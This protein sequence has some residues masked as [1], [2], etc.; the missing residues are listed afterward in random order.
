MLKNFTNCVRAVVNNT[1]PPNSWKD[2]GLLVLTGDS[3]RNLKGKLFILQM[4]EYVTSPVGENRGEASNSVLEELTIKEE[5][6]LQ[7]STY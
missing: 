1:K 3:R 2:D 6:D 5:G 7:T 4:R